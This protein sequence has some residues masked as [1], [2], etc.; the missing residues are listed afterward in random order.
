MITPSLFRILSGFDEIYSPACYED[1]DLA[2]WARETR[3][4]VYYQPESVVLHHRA[5]TAAPVPVTVTNLSRRSRWI[6][7]ARWADE[8]SSSRVR[9]GTG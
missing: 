1:A 4:R 9:V 3:H 7:L 6:F 8:L 5:E 2:M